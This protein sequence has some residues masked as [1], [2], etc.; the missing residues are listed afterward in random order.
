MILT[1]RPDRAEEDLSEIGGL[2][3]R[4]YSVQPNWNTYS[5]A[6][7]DICAQRCIADE[8][9]FQIPVWQQDFQ[10]WKSDGDLI[11]AVFFKS[12]SDAA[13]IG[14]PAR[15]E[16]I[17]PMLD[18]AEAHYREKRGDQPMRSNQ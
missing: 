17:E 5:F 7:F 1:H 16:V 18:W 13:L 12:P 8:V 11:G 3:R 2:L 9:L 4:A 15:L 14:D 10:L 6:R